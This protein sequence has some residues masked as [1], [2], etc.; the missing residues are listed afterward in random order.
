MKGEQVCLP[1]SVQEALSA[2]DSIARALYSQLFSWL[3]HKV[4]KIINPTLHHQK[5]IAVLDMFGFEVSVCFS[6][7]IT[8]FSMWEYLVID[9]ISDN[10]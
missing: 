8:Y 10:L 9:S 2:R 3:V 4:N 6:H 1:L 5:S 7:F